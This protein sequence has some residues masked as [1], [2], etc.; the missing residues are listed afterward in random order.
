MEQGLESMVDG[1]AESIQAPVVL[2]EFPWHMGSGVVMQKV[3]FL[4]FSLELCCNSV[5]LVTV[6][7][8]INSG[9]SWY[10][11]PVDHAFDP[12]PNTQ[13]DLLRV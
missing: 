10:Q 11:L 7:I 12:P 13:H 4:L 3:N 6:D 8:S 2:H 9:S 5:Q 1:E